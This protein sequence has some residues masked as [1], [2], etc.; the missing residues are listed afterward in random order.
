M[1]DSVPSIT[2]F[3]PSNQVPGPFRPV[4]VDKN[5]LQFHNGDVDQ[6]IGVAQ[7]QQYIQTYRESQKDYMS[8]PV[9]YTAYLNTNQQYIQLLQTSTE[10]TVESNQPAHIP[11]YQFP[12]TYDTDTKV[13]DYATHGTGDTS[14]LKTNGGLN[15]KFNNNR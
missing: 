8:K 7:Q 4:A 6:S 12:T 15:V 13:Q 10:S 2:P 5:Q 11:Y 3:L 9:K 1:R 14:L